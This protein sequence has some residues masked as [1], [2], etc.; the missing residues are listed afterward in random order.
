MKKILSLFLVLSI[1]VLSFAQQKELSNRVKKQIEILK[2]PSLG[3][4][5]VQLSRITL[6]LINEDQ[7]LE[8][9]LKA[10]SGNK[11]QMELRTKELHNNLINN[12]KGGMTT[13]QAETFDKLKL[14]DKL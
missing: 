11:S 13:L 1:S 10:V 2:N 6:V 3:L 12:V 9:N 7:I 14:G 8:K 4:N 5:D